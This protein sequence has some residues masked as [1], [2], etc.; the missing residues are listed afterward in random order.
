MG[1]IKLLI[2]SDILDALDPPDPG[3][4]LIY[5]EQDEN[6]LLMEIEA[7]PGLTIEIENCEKNEGR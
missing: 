7:G 5:V 4:V 1:E 3:E 6:G 2:T